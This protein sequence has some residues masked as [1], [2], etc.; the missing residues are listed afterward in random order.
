MNDGKFGEYGD[1]MFDEELITWSI[2]GGGTFFY[3]PKHK[4]SVTN[5]GGTLRVMNRDAIDYK[6][7]YYALAGQQAMLQFDWTSKAHPSV[8]RRLYKQIPLPPLSE[9]RRIAAILD[10]AEA[11]RAKR[12]EAITK[13][14][15]LLQSLFLDMFGEPLANASGWREEQLSDVARVQTGG[16]PPS[17][18]DGMFD[19]D[20][21]FITPGD[22]GGEVKVWRRTLTNE[23]AQ[24]VR[25]AAPGS[26]LVCCIGATIGKMGIVWRESA[27]NQQINAVTW[28]EDVLPLF[29]YHALLFLSEEI[30][31]RGTSTTLPILKKSEFER[32]PIIVPPRERQ[33]EFAQVAERIA[34]QSAMA[35]RAEGASMDLFSSLQQR[36]FE[37]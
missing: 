24:R 34:S 36:L 17:S 27:F 3:R 7:L 28:T 35:V 5:V 22:L 32:L 12:R 33:R 2:D 37:N 26:T 14:D 16:T 8:I 11:L 19:G 4:F 29:G 31:H 20:V 30:A 18:E 21:P 10:K 25:T 15:Q 1:Y 6:Y 9:Q 23:G 13:L